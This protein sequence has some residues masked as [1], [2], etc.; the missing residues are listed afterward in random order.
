MKTK[1]TPT[2]LLAVMMC[3]GFHCGA[4]FASGAQVKLYSAKYGVSGLVVPFVAWIVNCVFIYIVCEYSRL[5]KAKSYRDVGLSIYW[6]NAV[7]GRIALLLWDILIF[8]SSITILGSSVAG[9]G[10]QLNQL[11]GLPYWIG[12]GVFIAVMVGILCLGKNIM[13]RLGKLSAHMVVLFFVV[14]AMGIAFGFPRMIEVLT[15]EAGAPVAEDASVMAMFKSGLTYG[16]VQL[17]SFQALTVMAGKFESRSDTVK[18]ALLSFLINCG[19]ML[20]SHLSLMA[21][22]PDILDSALPTMGIIQRMTGPLYFVLIIIYNFM[23]VM[24]YITAA[25][26]MAGGAQARYLPLLNKKIGNE[27]VCRIIIVVVFFGA[28]TALSSLG[29]DGIL[30]T[31]YEINA[32]CRLRVWYVPILILGPIAIHR[33]RMAQAK[34]GKRDGIL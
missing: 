3:F 2:Y 1:K 16:L 30:T 29:L 32:Y 8:M 21:Y 34:E 6:D 15:T 28:A 20:V 23:L 18:F 17:G 24:A 25:G 22:Y 31:L 13:E 5:I 26:G 11:L 9:G 10:A 14:C 27:L 7:V 19:A 33:V 4:G 12:C